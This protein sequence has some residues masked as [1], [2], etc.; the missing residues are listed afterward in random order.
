MVKGYL[1][2]LTAFLTVTAILLLTGSFT[3]FLASVFGFVGLGLIFGGMICILP[4]L[5]HNEHEA[6][7]H[8]PAATAKP[9]PSLEPEQ[10]PAFGVWKSA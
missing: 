5:A 4:T 9:A 8:E 7:I 1:T 2:I 6:A 3:W 10:A